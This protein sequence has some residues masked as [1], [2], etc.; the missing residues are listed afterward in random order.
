MRGLFTASK[1]PALAQ[2]LLE[3]TL[4]VLILSTAGDARL[5]L[6]IEQPLAT[7][8]EISGI[9]ARA[10]TKGTLRISAP[11]GENQATNPVQRKFTET[12]A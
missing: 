8:I 12:F 10:L 5:S 4:D 1:S 6:P 7:E 3:L 9:I 2:P 11:N